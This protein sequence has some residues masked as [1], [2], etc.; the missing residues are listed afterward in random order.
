MSSEFKKQIEEWIK[1]REEQS[2]PEIKDI[3]NSTDP[4]R[5]IPEEREEKDHN[6]Y[7]K[8]IKEYFIK[9]L[10]DCVVNKPEE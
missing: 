7:S 6:F 3:T 9:R 5:L 4:G 2:R 8:K 1:R 10:E